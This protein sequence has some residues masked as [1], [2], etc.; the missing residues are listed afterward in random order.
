MDKKDRAIVR[1]MLKETKELL[2]E[3]KRRAGSSIVRAELNA[4][5]VVLTELKDRLG[6]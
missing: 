2:T 4:Q 6:V 3:N 1:K 5:V